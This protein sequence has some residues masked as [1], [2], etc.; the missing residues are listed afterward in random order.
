MATTAVKNVAETRPADR[1]ASLPFIGVVGAIYLIGVVAVVAS[2]IPYLWATTITPTLERSVGTLM[3]Q[4]FKVLVQIAAAVGLATIGFRLASRVSEGVRGAVFMGMSMLISVFFVTRAVGMI[5]DR[6]IFKPVESAFTGRIVTG[7]VG[8]VLLFLGW[9]ILN[10]RWARNA[11]VAL[12]NQGWFQV[13]G[14]KRS[15]G[16]KVRRL[17]MI[18]IFILLGSG[19]YVLNS[20]NTLS[21]YARDWT[22]ALP[23]T[24]FKLLLLP[25]IKLTL[26]IV[27]F[28]AALWFS[29]RVV[30]FPV[31]ADFLIATEAEMN[32]VSWTPR[33]ALL[34]DTV[35]VLVTVF[36]ITMFLFFVDMFWGALLSSPWINILPSS[37]NINELSKPAI[38]KVVW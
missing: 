17:T 11:M 31:F 10:G 34:R 19:V 38:E 1:T 30:N 5:L 4:T 33:K 37:S 8:G 18:G 28:I 27:L 2:G 36:I 26:P 32:K 15:Q 20:S 22:L 23:F 24:D 25:D 29:Y 16:Q 7:V 35:V 21:T 9:R 13:R 14:Y 6:T 12:E 3:D